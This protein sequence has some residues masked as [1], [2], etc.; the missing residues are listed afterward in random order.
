MNEAVRIFPSPCEFNSMAD[1]SKTNCLA[2]AFGQTKPSEN[3]RFSDYVLDTEDWDFCPWKIEASFNHTV[4]KYFKM[5]VKEVRELPSEPD[6][7]IYF[8]LYGWFHGGDFHVVRIE[9]DGT[10]VHKPDWDLPACVIEPD[11][12]FFNEYSLENDPCHFFV[13]VED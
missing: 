12:E 2:F 11:S 9:R 5:K 10:W 13:L 1:I 3:R 4:N 7:S 6:G 8:I